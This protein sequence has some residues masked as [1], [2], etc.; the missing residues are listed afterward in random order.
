VP[1]DKISSDGIKSPVPL[2]IYMCVH[3]HTNAHKYICIHITVTEDIHVTDE[4]PILLGRF[5]SHT[6][7]LRGQF[8]LYVLQISE[9]PSRNGRNL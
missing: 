4:V 7:Q 5:T 6:T 3:K 2:Y 1:H 8:S 9:V